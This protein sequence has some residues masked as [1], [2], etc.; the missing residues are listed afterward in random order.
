MQK[1]DKYDL[2]LDSV[3]TFWK[4]GVEL[5]AKIF[6]IIGIISFEEYGESVAKLNDN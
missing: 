5:C 2:E 1:L 3:I 4:R 6:D